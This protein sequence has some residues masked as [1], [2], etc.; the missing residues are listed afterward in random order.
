M[1]LGHF[2]RSEVIAGTGNFQSD[3]TGHFPLFIKIFLDIL[4]EFHLNSINLIDPPDLIV[5]QS[6]IQETIP[7][8]LLYFHR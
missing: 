3:S 1:V 4:P 2:F 5:R 8:T 6:N 7:K